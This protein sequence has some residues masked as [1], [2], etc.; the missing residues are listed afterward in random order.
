MMENENEQYER[1]GITRYPI[2]DENTILERYKTET[3]FE[4]SRTTEVQY[5]SV[6]KIIQ[7]CLVWKLS[8]AD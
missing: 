1:Q 5:Q 7:F 2:C 3:W 6:L 4:L 8:N